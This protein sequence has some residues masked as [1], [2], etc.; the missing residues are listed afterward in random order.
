MIAGERLDFGVATIH[1]S[2]GQ[3][4]AALCDGAIRNIAAERVDDKFASIGE[5]GYGPCCSSARIWNV[6]WRVVRK[7]A[8][9]GSGVNRTKGPIALAEEHRVA[10]DHCARLRGLRYLK[11]FWKSSRCASWFGSKPERISRYN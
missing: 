6:S 8:G 11:T 1:M 9:A 4:V 5:V 2:V 3:A 7:Q 10:W